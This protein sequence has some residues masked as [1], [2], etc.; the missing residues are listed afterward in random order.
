MTRKNKV[1]KR[2]SDDPN[3]L[4]YDYASSRLSDGREAVVVTDHVTIQ[5]PL[6]FGGSKTGRSVSPFNSTAVVQ[7]M[8]EGDDTPLFTCRRGDYV[9]NNAHGVYMHTTHHDR[10]YNIAP[11]YPEDVIKLVLRT[12]RQLK[13]DGVKAYNE[14]TADELNKRGV[15]TV[16]GRDWTSQMVH[17]LV[18]DYGDRYRTR[19]WKRRDT[20][21]VNDQAAAVTK[22][23]NM[24]NVPFPDEPESRLAAV[25]ES[26]RVVLADIAL[27]T[28]RV[29]ERVIDLE[30]LIVV[31]EQ[32]K[33]TATINDEEIAM[34]R[35]KAAKFDRL[36]SLASEDD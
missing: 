17:H 28:Q 26:A 27:Y 24:I 33:R 1:T 35:R 7:L 21:D 8:V 6:R 16:S 2:V 14:A 23:V 22:V 10:V 34:L 36:F 11:R 31:A 4:T 18:Q 25:Y 3:R 15:K 29:A 5:P 9:T 32:T 19:L 13:H 20:P 30:R 12:Q